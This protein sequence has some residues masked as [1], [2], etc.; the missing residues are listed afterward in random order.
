MGEAL[1]W[2]ALV[3]LSLLAML[4]LLAWLNIIPQWW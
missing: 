4:Y 1:K 3:A 2:I